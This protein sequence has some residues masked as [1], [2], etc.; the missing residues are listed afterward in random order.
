[1][2]QAVTVREFG[3]PEA[4][5]A[6]DRPVL[7]AGPGEV[8][9][10][11]R[12]AALNRR[13]LR[14]IAGLWPGATAPLVPGSD[15]AGVV[16]ALGA[17]VSGLSEGDEV[18]ILPSL[19]WGDD[20]GVLGPRFRILG[21][22]DDGTFAEQVRVPAEN[23]F[24][25]PAR[26]SFEE[27][28][29]LPLAGLTTW[30]ALF[31]RGRL[32]SGESVLVQGAGAGTSTFAVQF[33]RAAG[34]RVFVTSGSA[35]KIAR[36]VELGAEAGFDYREDAWEQEPERTGGGVDLVVDSAG[37]LAGERRQRALRRPHRLL[38]RHHRVEDGDRHPRPVLQAGRPDGNDDGQPG[39][40]PCA[41]AGLR[42]AGLESGRR[43]RPAAR[44]GAGRARADAGE[45]AVRQAR[46]HDLDG[47]VRPGETGSPDV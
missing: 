46:A 29:A 7:H 12:A 9:I 24:A 28:A 32:R 22:P 45:R 8:V 33:A 43:L 15:G 26:F 2:P 42:D 1:M 4:A 31:K 10:D 14:V 19:D 11:L 13:D 6:E 35:E 47:P 5:L 17:G 25:K 36:A 23:V 27:A 21:G 34:A 30:R 41:P 18:L 38:R 3:G 40:F 44:R 16:R 37:H 20:P 39:R